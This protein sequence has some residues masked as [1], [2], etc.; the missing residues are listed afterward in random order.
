MWPRSRLARHTPSLLRCV[1]RAALL[2]TSAA[3]AD[4][5][6]FKEDAQ[7]DAALAASVANSFV[8]CDPG[9]AFGPPALVAGLTDIQARSVA[10][11][12]LSP[13]YLTGY[14]QATGRPDG[15]GYNDLYTATRSRVDSPFD[16]VAPIA[17]NAINTLF[18]E[19][20][21]TVT[22]NGLT[23][24]FGREERSAN[25]VHVF[26]ATRAE[27]SLPFGSPV[28]AAGVNYADATYDTTPFF[29]EDG[30]ILYFASSR[31]PANSTD[32]YRATLGFPPPK[33]VGEV[34]TT[35][36]ELAP[37]VTP[38]DLT[39]YFGSDRGDG[40]ARGSYDIWMATRPSTDT[41]FSAPRNVAELNS[42]ALDLPTFVTRDGCTLYFSS[43][44]SGALLQYV[45]AKGHPKGGE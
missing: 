15:V 24:A 31:V 34:N 7:A 32:I 17:G 40:S 38:D 14:F 22:G 2:A 42:A 43:T 20:D 6:P 25:P 12:R 27:T 16:H 11:L 26:W 5:T 33:P 9:I 44:R 39:I 29:R 23:I 37:V 35:S 19:F 28:A 4:C 1:P 10:G 30:A 21:P 36:T 41:P 8:A 13:D 45:A 3:A 18:E